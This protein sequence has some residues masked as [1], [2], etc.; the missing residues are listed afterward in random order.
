MVFFQG[1][2]YFTIFTSSLAIMF[3]QLISGRIVAPYL[4]Q[5]LFT[6]S[7]IIAT[8]LAGIAVGNY[9]GGRIA[10]RFKSLN[11]VPIQFC[12]VGLTILLILP[13]NRFLGELALLKSMTWELR[14]F[15]HI[16]LLFIPSFICLG[17]ISPVLT[18]FLL[19]ISS[20]EGKSIGIFYFSSLVGSLVGTFLTG[21]YL[22]ANVSYTTLIG[23]SIFLLFFIAFGYIVLRFFSIMSNYLPHREREGGDVRGVEMN[24]DSEIPFK[25]LLVASFWA[26]AGIMIV[27]VVAGRVLA[28]NFGNSLYTWTSNIG[29]ILAGLSVGGYLGGYLSEHLDRRKVLSFFWFA[30]SL[31]SLIIPLASVLIPMIPVLWRFSWPVQILLSTILVFGPVSIFFGTLPPVLVRFTSGGS[32]IERGRRIGKLYATNA[33]GG[34]LG[35]LFTAYIAITSLG[36][37]LTLATVA[38]VSAVFYLWFSKGS[39]YA[40]LYTFVVALVLISAVSPGYPWDSLALQ[41]AVKSYHSEN[42]VYEKESHYNYILVKIADP[43]RPYILDLVLDKMIHNR[44]NLR[45]PFKLINS[46]EFIFDAIISQY[47]SRYSKLKKGLILGGGAYTFCH[48]LEHTYPNAHIEV[49]EIDEEVTNTAFMFF[50][51]PRNTRLHIY[52]QDAR[53]R[54]DDILKVKSGGREGSFTSYDFVINDSFSDYT[55]PFHLTTKEFAEKIA[56]ILSENGMYMCNIIDSLATGRLLSAMIRTCREIYPHIYVLYS[57]KIPNVRDTII[58]VASRVELD[59]NE[60][61]QFVKQ[62]YRSDVYL[63]SNEEMEG[64]IQRASPP[65]LTDSFA[66][67]ENLLAPMVSLTEDTPYLRRLEVIARRMN[68]DSEYSAVNE[69]M[70]IIEDKPNMNDAYIVLLEALYREGR[71][72]EVIIWAK[73]LIDKAPLAVRGYVYLGSAY[74]K[75]DN[76]D[77]AIK[78][79]LKALELD[80]NLESVKVSLSSLYIRKREFGK[81][82]EILSNLNEFSPKI[83]PSALLNLATLKYLQGE[84]QNALEILLEAEKLQ[85]KNYEIEKQIAVVYL[86]LGE[87]EKAR[88]KL[89]ECLKNNVS[90]E[91]EILR[92]VGLGE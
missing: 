41:L 61:S 12:M 72:Q 85:P 71:F 17:T 68:R 16:F 49:A 51:L 39:V 36:S 64:L 53:N 65:L 45:E 78:A 56:S 42:I 27:E 54:V 3:L 57:L 8:T 52:N 60:I 87:K 90:I 43:E 88:E 30:T 7:G 58:L 21:F 62:K 38:L 19:S 46:H 70:E 69:V 47:N 5:N 18:R 75:M 37:A 40:Y 29:V 15:I 55:V 35:V 83:R 31:S 48:Y 32:Q 66:P 74:I 2:V 63:L 76:I 79:W 14:I 59:S 4:G 81:A 84:Y 20:N 33:I 44:R 25:H 82:E 26:G 91:P 77:S 73:K 28:K 92:E 67:V 24:Q 80:P 23:I 22:I 1:L 13:L 89:L 10:D 86:Q 50:G 6:W 9:L 34:V 11:A